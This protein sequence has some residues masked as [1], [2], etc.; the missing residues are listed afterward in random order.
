[1]IP[2]DDLVMALRSWR[3]RNGMP[4]STMTARSGS[5]PARTGG[6]VSGSMPAARGPV[7]GSMPAARGPVSGSMPAVAAPPRPPAPLLADD[8]VLEVG[9]AEVDEYDAEGG[10]FALGFTGASAEAESTAI[11]QAPRAGFVSASTDPG[12]WAAGDTRAPTYAGETESLDETMV[13]D[14]HDPP[15]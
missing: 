9:A 5:G 4:T 7:S 13:G 3:E 2:Y 10:D 14:D 15:R 11:G 1:M 12:G 6:P 8:D